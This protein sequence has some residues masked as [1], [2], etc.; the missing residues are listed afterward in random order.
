MCLETGGVICCSG[1][2]LR[3]IGAFLSANQCTVVHDRACIHAS[4]WRRGPCEAHAMRT[5]YAVT[6]CQHQRPPNQESERKYYWLLGRRPAGAW[7]RSLS[8]RTRIFSE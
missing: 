3:P 7:L 2:V 4:T 6:Y 5:V 1:L 8:T